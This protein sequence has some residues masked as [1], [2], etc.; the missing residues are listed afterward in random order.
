V[1]HA[2]FRIKAGGLRC[3]L[4]GRAQ[5]EKIVGKDRALQIREGGRPAVAAEA[6]EAGNLRR[7]LAFA[8]HQIPEE[9]GNAAGRLR[10]VLTLL[11][12]AWPNRDVL[13]PRR[14][15]GH[16]KPCHRSQLPRRG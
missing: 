9:G 12:C 16:A 2:K 11:E 13:L 15:L 8:R 14:V 6:E 3:R 1:P 7:H 5:F 10:Q 4:D